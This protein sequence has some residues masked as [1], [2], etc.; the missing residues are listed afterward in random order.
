MENSRPVAWAGAGRIASLDRLDRKVSGVEP[1]V[2]RDAADGDPKGR[3]PLASGVL[4][5]A[6]RPGDRRMARS[7]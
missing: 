4:A 6:V 5:L 7:G 1:G 2:A 3:A